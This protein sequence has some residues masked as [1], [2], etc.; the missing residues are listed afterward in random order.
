MKKRKKNKKKQTHIYTIAFIAIA[1]LVA[2]TVI[3]FL[4]GD[5]IGDCGNW[6]KQGIDISHHQGDID[7]IA[8]AQEGNVKYAYIKATE[9]ESYHD[10]LYQRNVMQARAAGIPIGSYHYFHPNIPVEK[11]Y[12]NFMSVVNRSTQDLIPVIDVEEKSKMTNKQIRDSVQKFVEIISR[13]WN[14]V[15]IIYTHQGFYNDVFKGTLNNNNLWIARYGI[16]K[17]KLTPRL[18]DKHPLTIWQYSCRGR[19]NGIKGDVDLNTLC[20][21]TSLDEIKIKR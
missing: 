17:L 15:P 19:I 8:I 7:W 11:Q 3:F 5:N 6:E 13:N 21:D 9:G 20:G 10:P 12:R 18:H 14:V 1:I 2:V 16:F 4:R